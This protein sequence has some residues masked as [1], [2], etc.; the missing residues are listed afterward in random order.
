MSLV[1]SLLAH[2]PFLPGLTKAFYERVVP[3][4]PAV[5]EGEALYLRIFERHFPA[6]ARRRSV[7]ARGAAPARPRSTYVDE[8]VRGAP[9][10]DGFLNADGIS[11]LQRTPPTNANA[12]TFARELVF[13]WSMWRTVMADS[14]H[15]TNLR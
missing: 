6:L 13:Y 11:A 7:P 10:D 4:P 1:T 3:I 8:A 2:V 5:R 12:D 9:L 14:P 15:D